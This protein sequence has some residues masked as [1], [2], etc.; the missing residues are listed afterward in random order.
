VV[1]GLVAGVVWIPDHHHGARPQPVVA[2]QGHP[3]YRLTGALVSFQGCSD[4]LSYIKAQ[5][6]AIVGPYGLQSGT[7][8][9]PYKSP[10]AVPAVAGGM[11]SQG[12][13]S[14][15]VSAGPSSA[16]AGS[17][18]S[19]QP[20]STFSQTNDQVAG[21]DEPDTVK[22]DGHTVV[23]LTGPTLRVLDT[24][25]H[26]LGSLQLPGD[27]SG[28]FLLDGT[29]AVVFSS[30][31]TALAVGDVVQP[32][33]PVAQPVPPTES[34]QVAVV[35]LSDPTHPQLVRTFELDGTI[36]AARL[37]AQQVNLVV[38]TDGP[39]IDFTNPS[40]G[41][42]PSAAQAINKQLIANS[43]LADWLPAWQVEN[44]NGSTT[45]R[46]PI[47]SCDAV[48]RPQQ[49]SG[50]STVSVLSLDP[51]SS[52][53]GPGTSVVG[54]GDTVYATADHVYVAGAVANP[55]DAGAA[56]SQYGCCSVAP[57][58]GAS[59]RIYAFDT[60]A[61]GPPVFVASG[62]VPGWLLN[63]YAMDEDAHG[64]LRVASTSMSSSGA[65]NSQISV[66]RPQGTEL[67][68]T[69]SVSGLGNGQFLRAVRF[70]GDQAY[71]VTF[72]TFD[73]LYV[74]DLTNPSKP[75]VSGQLEQPGYSEFLYPLPG[76]RLLGVGVQIT[77]NEPSG[78]VVA[79]YNVADPAHPTQIDSSP[80]TQGFLD[81]TQGFD[82]HAFLYWPP[83]GL[84]LIAT[85][86]G[87]SYGG[88]PV[89]SPGGGAGISTGGP[90][91]VANSV[92]GSV[93]AYQ[94]GTDGHLSRTATLSHSNATAT[95]SI[96]IGSSVWV[97]TDSGIVTANLTDL[98]ATTWRPY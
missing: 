57:P 50:T 78:V 82:P 77:D 96:V 74:V 76:N 20:Q 53:P 33:Y 13:S 73:P 90:A 79:T 43:T 28:G 19:A 66:L 52:S 60:P 10:S 61:S 44:P 93:A 24:N 86:T 18:S 11:Q 89:I 87:V 39:R 67:A 23:T 29:Q 80:L 35:D 94:I 54:A 22:T 70:L 9:Y 1:A 4:Y 12:A 75:V 46:Q 51:A 37:V 58:V 97:I 62:S 88:P 2:Q 72:R 36:V 7:S 30:T 85:P 69:G 41:A 5:A 15:A 14:G 3:A 84:A 27:T 32:E 40:A 95:R 47:A 63:S 26:T 49:A 38:R 45:A 92:G 31:D 64:L 68:L 59:T 17:S 71:V 83:V 16:A 98:P 34:A 21:V 6:A 8:G 42:D 65:S 56:P 55:A 91:G 25:A 81:G 48:A